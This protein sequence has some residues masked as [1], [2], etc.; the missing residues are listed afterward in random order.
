MDEI[1]KEI[2]HYEGLYEASPD[3]RIRTVEGKTT[4][5]ARY[6]KRVWKQRILKQKM[7]KSKNGRLDAMVSLWKDGK[8]HCH[9]VS[10]I[11]ATTFVS[12]NLYTNLTVNHKDG[13]PLNNN[14]DN[15]EW[16]TRAEN[17]QYG[18]AN[19]QYSSVQKPVY[20]VKDDIEL[21]FNS[22]ND[23]NKYLGKKCSYISNLIKKGKDIAISKDGVKYQIILV[24]SDIC[25][26]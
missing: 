11:I 9:L 19:G 23:A 22:Y 8:P 12:D 26:R 6:K 14:A 18:Y 21:Y 24:H 2:P 5:S 20:L 17:I 13:N 7:R 3:G 25:L 4:S 1:W 16:L 10:R 15:L